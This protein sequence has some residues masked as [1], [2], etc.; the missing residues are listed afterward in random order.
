MPDDTPAGSERIADEGKPGLA[1]R[2]KE[3]IGERNAALAELVTS[4]ELAAG[5]EALRSQ[6]AELTAA[7]AAETASWGEEKELM[8][9][10][11]LDDEG[12]DV[13]RLLYQRTPESERPKSIGEWIG[14][15]RAE[16]ATIPRALQPY[17]G[18]PGATVVPPPR[19]TGDG[20]PAPTAPAVTPEALR[21]AREHYKKTGDSS[22]MAALS[23]AMKARGA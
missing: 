11:L 7:R 17:L 19:A 18:A 23:I 1:A 8:R 4:R 22:K 15:L 16:G 6:L 10:G 20:K 3:V 13:A 2:L 12:R 9:S 5:A 14:G 21:A